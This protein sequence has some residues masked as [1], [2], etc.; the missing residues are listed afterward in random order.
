MPKKE[1]WYDCQET[2]LHKRPNNT[3]INNYW[4]ITAF[5]KE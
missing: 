3:E 4:S 2:T 1:M 5:H